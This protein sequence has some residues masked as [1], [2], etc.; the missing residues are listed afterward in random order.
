M[1]VYSLA[2]WKGVERRARGGEGCTEA[3]GGW[4][5]VCALFDEP[6]PRPSSNIAPVCQPAAAA[7]VITQIEVSINSI[8]HGEVERLDQTIF[9]NL[10]GQ[11]ADQRER[12]KETV[13]VVHQGVCPE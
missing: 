12:S 4:N 10:H 3:A 2:G 5:E 6:K 8:E 11:G 7:S 1:S 13:L 9:H